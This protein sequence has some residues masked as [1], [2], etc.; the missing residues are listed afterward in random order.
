M[1]KKSINPNFKK[2]TVLAQNVSDLLIRMKKGDRYALSKAITLIESTQEDDKPIIA[3][4][5]GHTTESDRTRRIAITGSPGAGKS[6]CIEAL[7]QQLLATGDKVAILAIDPSST[8]TKGSILGDKTR[9]EILSK[10]EN[11]YIRPSAS[12]GALGGVTHM[13]KNTMA[14][15][16]MAGYNTILIETVGVGQSEVEVYDLVDLMILVA[17]PGAG[18]EIQ[19]IKRGIMELADI[20]V[21]NKADGHRVDLAKTSKKAFENSLHLLQPKSSNWTATVILASALH[22]EGIDNLETKISAFFET[23]LHNGYLQKNRLVQHQK[24]Y[25]SFLEKMILADFRNRH[26]IQGLLTYDLTHIDTS[27]NAY[28][29]AYATFNTYKG[30][31]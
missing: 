17:L 14:L 22:N 15:C 9:M 1:S 18:D 13:T 8:Q 19:G 24:W 29:K 31:Q 30:D 26:N 12:G 20:I 16:E 23:I 27:Q 21:I 6:T 28:A 10:N 2:K 3:E 7:G 5:L 11:A 4:L 25:N